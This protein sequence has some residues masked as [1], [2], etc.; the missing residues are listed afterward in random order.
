MS[1][2]NEILK[3]N[4]LAKFINSAAISDI[5]DDLGIN[6]VISGL[7]PNI[8]TAKIF[9]RANT[10]KLRELKPD[11]DFRGIYSALASYDT[12]SENEIIVVENECSDFAYFGDLNCSLAIRSGAAGAIIGGKTRDA[13]EVL[14]RNFPV[15][16]TGYNCKDVRKRAT[17]ESMNETICIQGVTIEPGC[18]IFADVNGIVVIPK[19]REGEILALIFNTIEKE[20]NVANAICKGENPFTI[21]NTV[22]EF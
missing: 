8:T 22:G 9:G 17:L 6:G 4:S 11:E 16:S 5:L 19:N 14:S 1:M 2:N 7:I 20:K 10:L 18:L 3:L 12:I 21:V 13:M 15:F